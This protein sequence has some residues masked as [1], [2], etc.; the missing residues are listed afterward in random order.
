MQ[1]R[2]EVFRSSFESWHS[3]FTQAAAFASQIAPERLITISHS[4]DRTE[5]VITVWYWADNDE[6]VQHPSEE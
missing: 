1:V 4:A 2:F 5:G 6:L 3:L